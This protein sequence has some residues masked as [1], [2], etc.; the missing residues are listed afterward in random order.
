MG[1]TPNY[2]CT[3]QLLYHHWVLPIQRK[4]EGEIIAAEMKF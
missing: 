2:K 4:H 1:W 3:I